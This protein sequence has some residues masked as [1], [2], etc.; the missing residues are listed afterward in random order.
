MRRRRIVMG[1]VSVA[2]VSALSL[3]AMAEPAREQARQRRPEGSEIALNARQI[4]RWLAEHPEQAERIIRNLRQQRDNQMGWRQLR[5]DQMGRL[6]Q[7][8]DQMGWR[9]QRGD[10]IGWR[11]LRGDQ[12]GRLQ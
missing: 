12:M 2:V 5:G 4:N 9:Q 1:L 7:R 8:G 6:Q 10:Q 11:Q 3:A